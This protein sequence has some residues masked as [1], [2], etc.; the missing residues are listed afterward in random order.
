MIKEENLFKIGLFAK[1]HGIKG[2]ITLSTD[3]DISDIQGEPYIVCD[4]DG[5]LVP[6]FIDSY[7]QKSNTAVLIKFENI[8]TE[9]KV[10][11]LTGKTAFVPSDMLPT[12]DDDDNSWSRITGYIVIDDKQA[13][14]GRVRDV[15]DST[16]NI[17]LR[18]EY[19]DNDILIPAAIINSIHHEAKTIEVILPEGFFEI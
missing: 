6:F 1:P 3:Y 11:L 2:E 16:M 18:V 12:Y 4:M 7:R 19:K 17:L 13:T 14:I 10:K 15:D 8:D 5:I 9:D